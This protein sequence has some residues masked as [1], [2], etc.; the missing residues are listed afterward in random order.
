LKAVDRIAKSL[1]QVDAVLSPYP[2]RTDEEMAA[3]YR[4]ADRIEALR[5]KDVVRRIAIS[6][7]RDPGADH[8]KAFVMGRSGVGKSTE[9]TRLMQMVGD[10]YQ[11][12]LFS[13]R[14]E[15]DPKRFAAFDVILLIC[16]LLAE[17][18]QKVTKKAPSRAIMSDL[19]AWYA[20]KDESVQTEVKA[21]LDAAGGADTKGTWWDK[22][23]GLFVT[24]K[25]GISYSE[26]RKEEVVAYQLKR[27]QPLV[28][29]ANRLIR[30]CADLL[31]KHNGKEWL[32]IGDDADKPGMDVER[33]KD[34]FLVHGA[35][36][37]VGLDANLIFNLPL[38]LTYGGGAKELPNLMRFTIYDVPVFQ[39][40]R[41]S[42]EA[43]IAF[44]KEVLDA[45]ISPELFEADQARRLII[46]SGANLRELFVMVRSASVEARVR[47]SKTIGSTDVDRVIANWR[48]EYQK[49]LGSSQ[50]TPNEPDIEAKTSR[51]VELYNSKDTGANV[52]DNV[53]G[54]LV[55]CS[56]V[57]E[58]NGDHWYAV[59]PLIVD[60]LVRMERISYSGGGTL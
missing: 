2:L 10:R 19:L 11:P 30:N 15:L 44:V 46:A 48:V 8:F 18:T 34:L 37:F 27:I 32:I 52:N 38:A 3:W 9:L 1:R 12:L 14:D 13:L 23:V 31:K 28:D 7:D 26:Y 6:L 25:G 33:V 17:E 21:V 54:H 29:I 50:F 43:S 59:H 40:D 41:Q 22:A 36:V 55:G 47:D 42:N 57:Q 24:I 16:I 5:G 45:R 35:S 49:L 4:G 60:A 58:F 51:L 39:K 56:A 53:L 20:E